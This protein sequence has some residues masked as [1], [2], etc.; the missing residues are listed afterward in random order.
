MSVSPLDTAYNRLDEAHRAW[1]TALD[2]YHRIDDFRAGINTAI[3]ALRNL[4][5]ALQK[6]KDGLPDF[7]IWYVGWQEKMRS[8]PILKELHEAG[9]FPVQHKATD[10]SVEDLPDVDVDLSDLEDEDAL[11]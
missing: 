7:D 6:H 3:Q 9:I 4:T 10:V 8:N 2:G 11:L 1:H 5:F